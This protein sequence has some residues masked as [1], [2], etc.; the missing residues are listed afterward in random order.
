MNLLQPQLLAL[1]LGGI[2]IAM[3]FSAYVSYKYTD[4][5]W[6]VKFVKSQEAALQLENRVKELETNSAKETTK[7]VTKYVDKVREVKVKGDTIVKEVPVYVNKEANAR[8][9]VSTGFVQLHD[10]AAKNDSVPGTTGTTNE[11]ASGVELSDVA[12]IVTGNYT[13]YHEVK[14]QLL[15]LQEWVRKQQELTSNIKK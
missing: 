6:S 9:D 11:K 7:V 5:A 10:A 3:S 12:T 2:A 4:N 1:K 14:E 15:A 8:C 13:K